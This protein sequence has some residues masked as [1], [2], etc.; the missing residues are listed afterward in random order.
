MDENMLNI[1]NYEINSYEVCKCGGEFI[2]R[3]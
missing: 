3:L 2:Y 1:K